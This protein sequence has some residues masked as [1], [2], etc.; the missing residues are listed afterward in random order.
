M[1]FI[2]NLFV[3][4]L[5]V[6][7]LLG[8][9]LV[10]VNTF[11]VTIPSEPLTIQAT[12]KPLVMLALG[13]DHRMFY[14]AYP[15]NSDI[16]GDGVID[17]RFKPY[18]VYA[19]MFNSN[20][21]Y[22]H[23]GSNDNTGLFTPTSTAIVGTT[24]VPYL[25][26]STIPV[27]VGTKTVAFT[28]CPG[29]WS[30]N[31]L[32]YITT[33]RIDAL[34]GVL[35]G[36]TREIDS[37][38]QTILRRAYIPQDA[39]SWGKE[40]TSLAVDG[41][42]IT[43][44]TP[45]AQPNANRRHFFGSLT[46]N[47]NVN[48]QTLSD[49]SSLPPWLSV[50]TNSAK[51]VWEWA[52]TERPV[53]ADGT[54]GG[55]RTNYTVRVE[56][57]TSSFNVGCKLYPSGAYK[58]VGLL[59]DYGENEAALFGLFS[60]SY[61]SHLSGGRLRKVISS[62]KNE[63]D[64]STGAFI[65]SV[66]GIVKNLNAFRLYG[67]NKGS[68]N[69]IYNGGVV[70]NRTVN[71]GEF[72]DWGNPL[73]EMMYDATRYLAN[74]GTPT[75]AYIGA[76]TIDDEIGLSRPAWDRPYRQA[77]G[78]SSTFTSAANAPHCARATLLTISDTNISF[79]S[80][81][82]PGVNTNFGAGIA[83]DLSGK[84]IKTGISTSLSV[85]SVADF[86][87]ANEP[88]ITG[89]KFI[90]QS[91]SNIDAGPTPKTV[92]SLSS[93]RGLA[94]E[95][96]TKR[97]SYYAAS[98]AHF[99]K[100]NDLNPALQGDQTVN[101]FFIALASP[102]PRITVPF[103]G[104]K[105]ISLLPFAKS[106]AGAFGISPAKNTYQPTNQIVDFYVESIAN[107]GLIDSNPSVNGGRYEAKFRINYEDVEQ[108]NDHD[109]DAIVSYTIRANADDTLDVIL[110]TLYEGG[111]V[112]HRMGYVISGTTNDGT[113]LVVQDESDSNPYYLSVPPGRSP[114]YCDQ[115]TPPGDCGRLPYLGG[116][117]TAT[118]TVSVSPATS[119][120]SR[121]TF[122]PS[123]TPAA[124][125]LQD[126]MWFAAKWGGFKEDSNAGSNNNARPD[127]AQEWDSDG[128]G[129]PDT[130]L[131]VQN[132]TKLRSQLDKALK[133][134][135][136]TQSSSSNLA[137]NVS[138]SIQT[139]SFIYRAT[140]LSGKWAGDV[141]ALSATSLNSPA[142]WTA[143]DKMPVWTAR[144]LF[145]NATSATA[146]PNLVDISATAFGALPTVD[147]TSLQTPDIYDYIKGKRSGEVGRG[148][149]LRNRDL[150]ALGGSLLSGSTDGVLG[151]I[152]NS[153][154]A[155]DP[156]FDTV[157]IGAND[158]MLHAFNGKSGTETFAIIPRQV[159][160]RLKNLA[161]LGYATNHEYFV[162]G[163]VSVGFKFPETNMTKYV[164]S[165]LGRGDK[166]LFSINPNLGTSPVTPSLLW[167]YTPL[168]NASAATDPDLGYMLSR[169]VFALLNNGKAGLIVGNGY[170]STSG[171]AVLYIFIINAD[172]TLFQVKKLDTG[173]GGDNGLAGATFY[174]END[175]KRADFVYAG[176]L[177]GN[178]WKFDISDADPAKW[179]LAFSGTSVPMFKATNASS[180]PQPITAPLFS[181]YNSYG[182]DPNVNKV[183]VYFG[184]GS[185]FKV[186]D[187]NNLD[188]Q[189]WYGLIDDTTPIT[190]T[191]TNL[192]P[193]TIPSYNTITLP[194]GD[195]SVR[196]VSSETPGDMTGKR[197]WYLDFNNPING[198]RITA[199]SQVLRNTFKP[200]VQVTSFYPINDD[201]C[202]PGGD[203]WL[204]AV[205][206]F[207]GASLG[208]ELF[209]GLGN[210][211]G[212]KLSVG[213]ATTPLFLRTAG[214]NLTD[215]ETKR[216]YD[217]N[218]RKGPGFPP[219]CG[220][221]VNEYT[222]GTLGIS[223]GSQAGCQSVGIRGRISW[224]EIL[225]D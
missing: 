117:T 85:S 7:L 14:E 42:L 207:T 145:M 110:Q 165:L 37:N 95:E 208:V 51:R 177:K 171:N 132:P 172:G 62:F 201:I 211:S 135:T 150:G 215:P 97:G 26:T 104:G 19:G 28:K 74:K 77:S 88:G 43:D 61:D 120:I 103:P 11:A 66:D 158:G 181:E 162:D 87:S 128:D 164:Y 212:R 220:G 138:G 176:D 206:P 203:S 139:D 118:A 52:S 161:S 225:K 153:S 130:Y 54:H 47:Q 34:R 217:G 1:T 178:V 196:S 186:G 219:E 80:D 92:A 70:G 48:C 93:I 133:E 154:P 99:S 20:T 183:F 149:S 12:A 86:I 121:F 13:R 179:K 9:I 159:I 41:F 84:H 204:N 81:Q 106:V 69:Q 157:Y 55:T 57:C 68:T 60:G 64:Q 31:W 195:V 63:V 39:H 40:Y 98:V 173:I 29:K 116:S 136:E 126:P 188:I 168:G 129:T 169:P 213:I 185:Y 115:A 112:K 94:P 197:G 199:R 156:D 205:N 72:P 180:T 223:G 224:R 67:F 175:D 155:Y 101:N 114:G 59:H 142:V 21:C 152:I 123:P 147:Q 198:E 170:N 193:R 33:S 83:T 192:Q 32:N 18:I 6:S 163:D 127:L 125:F 90:G 191:R 100:V 5:R 113:Y 53:L 144:R 4:L 23:N 36:G 79:D 10:G 76:N 50:V 91:G 190:G 137:A 73:A 221:N 2:Q 174:D 22:N 89:L 151:D 15:D 96:P 134:I 58:P 108:G 202:V 167:E 24:S 16:D 184:T 194:T 141:S 45:L 122:T 46:F 107:S 35:Y 82:L 44:Y 65:T 200:S 111:S 3:H 143:R 17:I 189:S 187:N 71:Q 102:I 214:A 124:T 30:G 166:G 140:Y 119:S 146:T 218:A 131:F 222:S 8:S 25:I 209:L 75:S 38:T 78:P 182:S 210:A 109:M 105:T 56:V 216:Y 160:P 148:G 27:S 49:C